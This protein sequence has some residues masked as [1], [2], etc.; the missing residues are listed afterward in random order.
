MQTSQLPS[1]SPANEYKINSGT[2]TPNPVS[3]FHDP[4]ATELTPILNEVDPPPLNYEPA[5]APSSCDCLQFCKYFCLTVLVVVALF[6]VAGVLATGY[7]AV[8]YG[9]WVYQAYKTYNFAKPFIQHL[10]GGF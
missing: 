8:V 7:L 2:T 9:P 4:K 5:V 3:L 1:I 6:V 10:L